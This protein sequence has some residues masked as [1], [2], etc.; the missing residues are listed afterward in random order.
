MPSRIDHDTC[1]SRFQP[2][3]AR[4]LEHLV[5]ELVGKD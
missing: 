3:D 1:P 5:G 2:V 4:S